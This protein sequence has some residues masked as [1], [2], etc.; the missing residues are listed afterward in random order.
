VVFVRL[1]AVDRGRSGETS[2]CASK[3]DVRLGEITLGGRVPFSLA[4]LIGSTA[5]RKLAGVPRRSGAVRCAAAK[6]GG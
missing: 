3:F 5:R 4:A 6:A 1:R 2:L